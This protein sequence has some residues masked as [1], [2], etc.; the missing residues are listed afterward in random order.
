M[1]KI[2]LNNLFKS[3][4]NKKSFIL[5]TALVFRLNLDSLFLLY[6]IDQIF[7][8]STKE[9]LYKKMLTDYYMIDYSLK[10]LFSNDNTDQNIA[11]NNFINYY[12]KLM[13][14]LKMHN[15][16]YKEYLDMLSDHEINDVKRKETF[17]LTDN[18]YLTI[19]NYQLKYAIPTRMIEKE[20]D[21]YRTTYTR[22]INKLLEQNPV[23][24]EKYQ[25]LMNYDID[26][27]RSH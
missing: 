5:E 22:R 19:L 11:I 12:N 27:Y 1:R 4:L 20:F 23:L 2:V 18:D 21:I 17:E 9:E 13:I 3:N 26:L 10:Y 25:N 6:D 15:E 8:V 16:T 24:Q 14:A 7:N